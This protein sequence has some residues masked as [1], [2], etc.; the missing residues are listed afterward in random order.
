MK[1]LAKCRIPVTCQSENGMLVSVLARQ[2]NGAMTCVKIQYL[3]L[4]IGVPDS[5][6]LATVSKD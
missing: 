1:V 4:P 2:F 5:S 6:Q 3:I